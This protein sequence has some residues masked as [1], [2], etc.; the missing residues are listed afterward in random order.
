MKWFFSL[1][2]GTVNI[3]VVGGGKPMGGENNWIC[4]FEVIWGCMETPNR[5]KYS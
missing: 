1:S 4:I 3:T 5:R 2:F